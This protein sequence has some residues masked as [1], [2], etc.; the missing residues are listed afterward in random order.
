MAGMKQ[1]DLNYPCIIQYSMKEEGLPYVLLSSLSQ[2]E[3][4][5]AFSLFFIFNTPSGGER[6]TETKRGEERREQ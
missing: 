4:V 1:F 5:L 2:S 6:R 3:E